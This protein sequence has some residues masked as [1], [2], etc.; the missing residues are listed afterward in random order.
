MQSPYSLMHRKLLKT[1][2]NFALEIHVV[3]HFF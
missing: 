1:N 2:E 3:K